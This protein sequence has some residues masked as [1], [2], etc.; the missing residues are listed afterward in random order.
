[1]D[2]LRQ[3]RVPSGGA[4]GVLTAAQPLGRDADAHAVGGV[5]ALRHGQ[6]LTFG[7][8]QSHEDERVGAGDGVLLAAQVAL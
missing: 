8:L 6:R 4:P 1:M 5:R 3:K 7:Q 2:F